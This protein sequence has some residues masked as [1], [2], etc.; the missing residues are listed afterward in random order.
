MAVLIERFGEQ[1]I[2]CFGPVNWPPTSCDITSL[3][4]FFRGYVKSKVYVDKPATVQAFGS[5][6]H[7]CHSPGTGQ[8]IKKVTKN[9]DDRMS[10]VKRSRGGHLPE[11][12]F[13][14]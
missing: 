7:S 14:Q 2:S 9:W 11:I 1:L 8:T 12:V 6:H 13:K 4:F 3:D 10:Y 5:Q